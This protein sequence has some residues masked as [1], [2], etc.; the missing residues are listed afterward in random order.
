M[1]KLKRMEG[2]E[3]IIFQHEEAPTTGMRHLQGYLILKEKHNLR[4][5]K[6]YVSERANFQVRRGTMEQARDYCRK[7]ETHPAG[8]PRFE[9]GKWPEKEKTTSAERR[10]RAEAELEVIKET[11]K[12]PRDIPSGVLMQPGFVMAYK[13]LTADVLGPF[14]PDLKIITLVGP[15]GC[16]KS[17]AVQKHFPEHGL[18]MP[19]NSGI[20][21][22]NPESDVM[23]FEEFCGQIPIQKM[24]QLLDIYQ[25]ALEV[26]GGMAPARYTTV[27]ITSNTTPDKWYKTTERIDGQDVDI[28]KKVDS[29]QALWDRIGYSTPTY[30][31]HRTC[32]H[33][34]EAPPGMSIE[35]LRVWF[36]E[37]VG[38]FAPKKDGEGEGEDAHDPQ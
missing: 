16:G 24:R 22:Q 38:Q 27:L 8:S 11:H 18:C 34:F 31:G 7:E 37:Q 2:M 25:Y 21:F 6:R 35:Q 29:V 19:G 15:P 26:K 5:L 30:H 9:G 20:W 14:R 23:V 12:R 28:D 17:W 4:W 33:Y 32:G 13:M 3:Y 1:E 10:E 36:D